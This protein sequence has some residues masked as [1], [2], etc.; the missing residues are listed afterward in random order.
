MVCIL[1]GPNLGHVV[2]LAEA[3]E[4]GVELL[5]ALLVGFEQ[6]GADPAGFGELL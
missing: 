5:H 6:L 1:T 2:V 3:R 4:V